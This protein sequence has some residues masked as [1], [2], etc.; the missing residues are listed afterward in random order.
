[1]A[2]SRS[3]STTLSSLIAPSVEMAR[4]RSFRSDSLRATPS[5][6]R[7]R[8]E[9][10]SGGH[11]SALHFGLKQRLKHDDLEFTRIVAVVVI[12]GLRRVNTDCAWRHHTLD[13]TNGSGG[14]N[15]SERGHRHSR[16]VRCL[17]YRRSYGYRVPAYDSHHVVV[18]GRGT[19]GHLR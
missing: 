6:C 18:C 10:F 7:T 11:D 13:L 16:C 17:L 14:S 4:A 15:E 9:T 8:L 3:E 1:M 19:A 12:I 2:K 5:L